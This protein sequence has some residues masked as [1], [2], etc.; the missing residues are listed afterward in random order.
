MN[1]LN[2]T[3]LVCSHITLQAAV[4]TLLAVS[5][6]VEP[7]FLPGAWNYFHLQHVKQFTRTRAWAIKIEKHV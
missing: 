6:P 4:T 3:T 7:R 1:A 5:L 2:P